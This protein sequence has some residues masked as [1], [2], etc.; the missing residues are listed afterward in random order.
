[1]KFTPIPPPNIIGLT[2]SIAMGAIAA[3][4]VSVLL[5]FVFPGGAGS[6]DESLPKI[7]A[8]G[9][10]IS[11]IVPFVWVGLFSGL[12]AAYWLVTS[13]SR[14][15]GSA[16][17]AILALVAL[18]MVYPVAA[19]DTARPLIAIVGNLVTVAAVLWTA[20]LVW[21]RS[22]LG[23]GLVALVALWVCI[24]TVGLGVLQFNPPA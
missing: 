20:T 6:L 2:I 10:L 9:R 11:D 19:A 7:G 22:K 23:A 8:F 1:M 14:Q 5:I 4:V 21:S 24:A 15:I 17:L 12:G 16:G 3:S 13:K 18:C